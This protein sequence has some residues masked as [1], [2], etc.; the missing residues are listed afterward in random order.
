MHCYFSGIFF[1]KD[2]NQYK[3]NCHLIDENY[4]TQDVKMIYFFPSASDIADSLFWEPE[5]IEPNNVYFITGTVAIVNSDYR[6]PTVRF[7][8]RISLI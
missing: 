3:L 8:F 6:N 4:C 1:V 7:S 5:G 2:I